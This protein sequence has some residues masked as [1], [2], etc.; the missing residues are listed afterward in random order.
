[1]IHF[2]SL[3]SIERFMSVYIE[4]CGGAFPM[5]LAPEQARIVPVSE[6]FNDYAN[7][8]KEHL[9]KSGLRVSV[10]NASESLGKRIR[11]SELMKVPYTL[12]VGEKEQSAREVAVRKYGQ[13]DLGSK[14]M[15]KLALE[16]AEEANLKT[17][18]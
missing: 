4:H 13:G 15:D 3:G 8:L 5:W 18:N 9:A 11:N 7:E 10:D 2:A 1:M 14:P 16:L 6:K 12:V 17:S